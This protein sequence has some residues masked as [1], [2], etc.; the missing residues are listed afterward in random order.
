M[1]VSRRPRRLSALLSLAVAT[2][3]LAVLAGGPEQRVAL[4][5]G[6]GGAFLVWAGLRRRAGSVAGGAVALAGAVAVLGGLRVAFTRPDRIA[7][8]VEVV[9]GIVGLAV[10]AGGLAPL[11][12][13]HERLHVS[14]GTGLVF[15]S[16]LASTGVL[17]ASTPSLLVAGA[18]TVVSWDLAE[19]SINLAEHV[20]EEAET[21]RVELVHG[22]ASVLVGGVAVGTTTA[23]EAAGVSGLPL[24]AVLFLLAA[25]VT[26]TVV[27]YN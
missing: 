22:G 13:G 23:V 15:T 25:A 19:Q 8:R 2:A 1:T 9:P 10:L 6:A 5:L 21:V 26:L 17:G 12:G 3:A 27:L 18:A 11:Y 16:V 14:A 24:V 4:A 7:D 20:G